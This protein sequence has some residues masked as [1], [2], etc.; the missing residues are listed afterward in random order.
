MH[1]HM[2][3]MVRNAAFKAA[4]TLSLVA[5]SVIVPKLICHIKDDLNPSEMQKLSE[6]DIAIWRMPEGSL[7]HDG[8]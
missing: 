3:S 1:D 4:T 2:Q 7:Y 6:T 8:M 5:P